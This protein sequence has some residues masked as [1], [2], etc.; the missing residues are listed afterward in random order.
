MLP[1]CEQQARYDDVR[2][3][4][5]RLG[6]WP[7]S[8]GTTVTLLD[9]TTVTVSCY[10]GNIPYLICPS[11]AVAGTPSQNGNDCRCSYPGCWGD[12]VTNF[13]ESNATRGFFSAHGTGGATTQANRIT[14][15]RSEAAII[16][17]LSNTI[18]VSESVTSAS[19]TTY[20]VKGNIYC[21]TGGGCYS[22]SDC[23]ANINTDDP[24]T[25]KPSSTNVSTRGFSFAYGCPGVSGFLTAGPPNSMNCRNN[26]NN[27]MGWNY[28]VG[29]AS[30]N[31]S[32]GVNAVFADGSVRFMSET[33][34]CGTQT[35]KA[36]PVGKS[37]YGVWGA[38]GTIDGGETVTL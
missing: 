2:S 12:D 32:G 7:N 20:K 37:Q 38:L 22:P 17:G 13:A 11:D 6:Y 34:N 26:S 35:Y 27:H 15:A 10:D 16:D 31:H 3:Y 30:S 1:F 24:R 25:F 8:G 9:G 36:T 18:A 19:N 33:V 14:A 28:G 23:Q 21:N 29:S 4:E 5:T